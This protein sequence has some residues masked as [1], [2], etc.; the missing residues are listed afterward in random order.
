MGG[1]VR[2]QGSRL[3]V[4]EGRIS[5]QGLGDRHATLGA[6]VVPLEPA[7]LAKEGEKGQCSER[8]SPLARKPTLALGSR[9]G[10]ATR[11][12]RCRHQRTTLGSQLVELQVQL[13]DP[14]ALHRREERDHVLGTEHLAA[15]V[16]FL[17]AARRLALDFHQ[18]GAVRLDH[19]VLQAR[20]QRLV[21]GVGERTAARHQALVVHRNL[22]VA[23][24]GA[25]QLDGVELHLVPPHLGQERED[26]VLD[27][28]AGARQAVLSSAVGASHAREGVVGG[29]GWWLTT[30]R[31]FR[32]ELR[33][34]GR[35]EHVLAQR[36]VPDQV[37][38]ALEL[39]RLVVLVDALP[40]DPQADVLLLEPLLLDQPLHARADDAPLAV[41]RPLVR[42]PVSFNL[43][44]LLGV[45]FLPV[46]RTLV[47]RIVRVVGVVLE[48][49]VPPRVRDEDDNLTGALLVHDERSLS[50]CLVAPHLGRLHDAAL[51]LEHAKGHHEHGREQVELLPKL[52]C[53]NRWFEA[54]LRP[55]LRHLLH[56]ELIVPVLV[57]PSHKCVDLSLRVL[58]APRD[59]LAH[60]GLQ[61]V[62][63][64][65]PVAIA[66][67]QG[68]GAAD[69]LL[70]GH[71]AAQTAAQLELVARSQRRAPAGR[72][73]R[74]A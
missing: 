13:G 36:R 5:L 37:D 34:L 30:S 43:P 60:D 7:Q 45:V 64:Q 46:G 31:G 71:S 28:A 25:V 15:E 29:G 53:G 18:R 9:A 10:L 41:L 52:L 32:N 48:R 33:L 3:E 11:T 35:H 47:V 21:V 42:D 51:R 59:F 63:G 74:P 4:R 16:H 2:W 20:D 22:R 50:Q 12:R 73:A 49:P 6:E 19:L 57:E 68:E 69:R 17:A 70:A 67:E 27:A 14:V 1:W 55:R 61:L 56:R 62:R 8:G 58:H 26:E 44:L 38:H 72:K 66:V 65:Q 54:Q 40:V 23:V 24:E 39:L